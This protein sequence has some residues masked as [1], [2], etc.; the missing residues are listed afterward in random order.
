MGKSPN[1]QYFALIVIGIILTNHFSLGETRCAKIAFFVGDAATQNGITIKTGLSLTKGTEIKTGPDSWVKVI[2]ADDSIVDIGPSSRLKITNCQAQKLD[3]NIDLEMA[4]GQIRAVINKLP[5]K[6]S[7]GFRIK[8]STS[9]LAVRGT[10]FFVIRQE[11][12]TGEISEQIGVSEGLLEIRTLF[13]DM[14]KPLSLVGGTEFQAAGTMKR[15]NG[16]IKVTPTSPVTI[17]QFTADEQRQFEDSSK[18]DF[19]PIEEQDEF[20]KSEKIT[21]LIESLF[22]ESNKPSR[23]PASME[24]IFAR[25]FF[26]PLLGGSVLK[27][28]VPVSIPAVGIWSTKK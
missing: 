22:L 18:I 21:L 26:N 24:T 7:G 16:M 25:S 3:R 20:T 19:D 14:M 1:K 2:L 11:S 15:V 6:N 17:D 27:E 10:E 13:D 28:P 9:I 4:V 8:T 5:K 12:Q 23:K